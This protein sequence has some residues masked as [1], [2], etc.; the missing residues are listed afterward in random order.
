M[1][2]AGQQEFR[3]KLRYLP[4]EQ[5]CQHRI[6]QAHLS[7]HPNEV[8]AKVIDPDE[9]NDNYKHIWCFLAYLHPRQH[10]KKEEVIQGLEGPLQELVFLFIQYVKLRV[11]VS[12]SCRIWARQHLCILGD[13][14]VFRVLKD[15][16]Y[17]P[18]G[19]I[20][21]LECRPSDLVRLPPNDF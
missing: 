6:I 4:S 3:Y 5:K 21:L 17:V 16:H 15:R 12:I 19:L 14:P 20:S 10:L 1:P 9:N 2:E 8:I 13:I 11:N 18:T 7:L